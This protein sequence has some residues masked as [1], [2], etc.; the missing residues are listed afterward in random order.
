MI[1]DYMRDKLNSDELL[2][3]QK[4]DY[5]TVKSE[6]INYFKERMEK[7]AFSLSGADDTVERMFQM[8]RYLLLSAS[9]EK[10]PSPAHL[11]GVWNDNVACQIG[12]TCDMHLDINTQ[13]NYW[14]SL[15]GDLF[16]ANEPLFSWIE[17]VLIPSGRITA[18][19]SYGLDG[20]SADLVSNIWGFTAPYWH[21]NISPCPTSGIWLI[22]QYWEYYL[23]SLDENFLRNRAFPV[24]CEAVKFFAGY[25]FKEG[26]YYSVGPSISPENSFIADDEIHYFSNGSTYEI[27]M[28]RELFMQYV[29]ACDALNIKDSLYIK[30]NEIIKKLLPYR[31]IKDGTLAEWSHDYPSADRQHRHTSHLLGLYPY[32]QITPEKTP[33]LAAASKKAIDTKLEP[34]ENWEDTGWARSLLALYSARLKNAKDVYFH[35]NEMKNM[36][37]SKSLLVMH[38]PTRGAAS[39]KEVYELDGNTGF[40]MSVIEALMQSHDDIIQ[41]LPA[42]P[43]NWKSGYIKGIVARG[44]VKVDITWKDMKL[45]KAAFMSLYNIKVTV[46]YMEEKKEILLIAHKKKTISLSDLY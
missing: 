30:A 6:N 4:L 23:H 27:L 7:V 42:L 34:Y 12:W 46:S 29:K 43:E 2:C 17:K 36:L 24:I 11:Q 1:T 26:E 19:K 31:V 45:V 13:M 44:N 10:S 25:V 28:V 16:E 37:T 8:G 39:F 33:E 14:L 21:S 15:E 41:L 3:G 40:S 32:C 5:E 35:I 18:K 9:S 22:S 20:W 38:P